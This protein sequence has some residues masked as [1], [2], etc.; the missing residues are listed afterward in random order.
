MIY[1]MKMILHDPWRILI[2][3]GTVN[4]PSSGWTAT[5]M[6]SSVTKQE[7]DD[8]TSSATGIFQTK[9]I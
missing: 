5:R 3:K 2:A 1:K 6:L 8:K 9:Y 4:K 7:N